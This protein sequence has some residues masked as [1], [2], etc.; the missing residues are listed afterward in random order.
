MQ[1][2]AFDQILAQAARKRA[3]LLSIASGETNAY[4]LLDGDGDGAPGLYIDVYA[5]HWLVQT[6]DV[7]FPDALRNRLPADCLSVWWKELTNEDSQREAPKWNS[8]SSDSLITAVENTIYY[9]ID[10]AAGYS[11][12]IFLY[13]RDNRAWLRSACHPGDQVLNL[14]AYTCAFS[15]A[16]GCAGAVTT[17]VDLSQNYLDW[18]RRNFALNGIE[19]EVGS[20]HRFF[21]WDTFDFLRM[22]KRQGERYRFIV[23]DPPTFSRNKSGKVFQAEK[24]YGSLISRCAEV[25]EPGGMILCSTNH[26]ALPGHK[27]ED[28]VRSGIAQASLRVASLRFNSMPKD[29]TGDAYLKSIRVEID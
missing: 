4:R 7:P 28:L 23:C 22:A 21:A 17:S 6:R 25:L 14:F 5:G 18:G 11:Q 1:P 24:N 16:A 26:R 15:V 9:T 10:F 2:A 12:G 3:A 20:A 19:D 27:F 8:G 13:Q 29:F